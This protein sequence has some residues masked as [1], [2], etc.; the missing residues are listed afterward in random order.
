M[1]DGDVFVFAGDLLR[2]GDWDELDAE[3]PWLKSLPHQHKLFVAGNHDRC[4]E[5]KRKRVEKMF[6]MDLIYLQ[7]E[8]LEIDGVKFWGSPWQPEFLSWA[9]NLPRGEALAEKWAQIPGDT[10]VLITHGPPH[11]LGDEAWGRCLGCRE[12]LA[13]AE[14]VRP[15]LHCYG[16]IHEGRGVYPTE[17]GLC[18]NVTAAEGDHPPMVFDFDLESRRCE[19]V[20]E[21]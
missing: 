10:D 11:G 4:F 19:L 17:W 9:F 16:H 3:L 21:Q 12:L 7:D 20:S 15:A 8:G 6:G 2:A 5:Q 18:A 14:R 13:A 1:P